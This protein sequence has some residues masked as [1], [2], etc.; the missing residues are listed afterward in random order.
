M[1]SRQAIVIAIAIC[2][3]LAAPG[4]LV[5]QSPATKS[6]LAVALSIKKINFGKVAAGTRSSPQV[7]TLTNK[8]KVEMS[9]PAVIVSGAGFSLD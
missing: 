6:K 8:S 7:V 3:D 2:A 1:F 4:G 9:A 5:A